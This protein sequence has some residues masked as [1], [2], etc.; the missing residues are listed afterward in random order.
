MYKKY[1]VKSIFLFVKIL[2]KSILKMQDKILSC[3]FKIKI[4]PSKSILH[5]MNCDNFCVLSRLCCDG[6]GEA[7]GFLSPSEANH[8]SINASYRISESCEI[9]DKLH[10][11][12]HEH[13]REK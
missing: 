11:K 4:L 7:Y 5:L 6:A 8:S 12:L 10:Y 9:N 1:L 13:D 2:F 3:I